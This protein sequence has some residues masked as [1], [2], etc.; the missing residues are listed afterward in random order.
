MNNP[1]LVKHELW[2]GQFYSRG[3]CTIF[4]NSLS[5]THTRK[6]GPIMPSLKKIRCETRQEKIF[7]TRVRCLQH[8]SLSRAPLVPST[9][10]PADHLT[11]AKNSS[12]SP[13]VAQFPHIEVENAIF[14]FRSQAGMRHFR[15]G[16]GK[17]FFFILLFL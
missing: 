4:L 5:P 14:P 12:F 6:K 9:P 13:L 2:A 15:P 11:L 17:F 10:T 7:Q 16:V 1:Q 8:L 3:A